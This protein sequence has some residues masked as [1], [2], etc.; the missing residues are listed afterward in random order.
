MGNETQGILEP[1]ILWLNL[2]FNRA[3]AFMASDKLDQEWPNH[4]GVILWHFP[5][6]CAFFFFLVFVTY[7]P[8]YFHDTFFRLFIHVCICLFKYISCWKSFW[9]LEAGSWTFPSFV[10]LAAY[11]CW[12]NITVIR[13][14][15]IHKPPPSPINSLHFSTDLKFLE[16]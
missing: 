15:I 4:C 14:K 16:L 6:V 1:R 2:H 12:A 7:T 13:N 10:S 5:Q 11:I 8:V 9:C 3:F